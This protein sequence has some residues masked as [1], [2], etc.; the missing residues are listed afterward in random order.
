MEELSSI[1]DTL[2]KDTMHKGVDIASAK[3]TGFIAGADI[4]QFTKF[5]DIDEAT[6]FNMLGQQILGKSGS[7]ENTNCCHD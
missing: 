7:I 6:Q 2:A 3:K 5:K 1:V 4:S